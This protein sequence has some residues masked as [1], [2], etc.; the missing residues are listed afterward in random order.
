[1]LRRLFDF[2][3]AHHLLHH[4]LFHEAGFSEDDAFAGGRRAVAEILR[5]GVDSG[6]F[7]VADVDVAAVFLLHGVH[8]ALVEALHGGLNRAR[9]EKLVGDLVLRAVRAG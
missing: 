2:S 4:A 6:E 7:A 3:I 1:L 8:G 5:E 9:Y